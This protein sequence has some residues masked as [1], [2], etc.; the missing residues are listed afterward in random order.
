M[1]AA[2]S[3]L[4]LLVPSVAVGATTNSASAGLQF[5]VYRD[6]RKQFR[7]RLKAANGHVIATSSEG[8][9]AKADCLSAI[10]RIKE[11]ARTATVEDQTK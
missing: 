3:A 9:K 8:Y 7:W 10:A 6:S 5:E 4:A 1:M 2:A 11:D